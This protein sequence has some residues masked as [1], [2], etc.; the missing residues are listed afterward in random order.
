M[1]G[2][3]LAILSNDVFSFLEGSKMALADKNCTCVCSG[4]LKM[5]TWEVSNIL[6]RWLA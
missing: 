2:A 6:R 3:V 4:S 1:G 5:F